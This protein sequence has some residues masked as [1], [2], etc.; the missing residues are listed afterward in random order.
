[1]KKTPK[2]IEYEN[3]TRVELSEDDTPELSEEWFKTAKHGLD[4]LAELIGEAAVA[5]LRMRGRPRKKDCKQTLTIRIPPDLIA[6][7]KNSG[8]GY[9]NKIENL[10]REAIAMGKF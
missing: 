7:I 3:K 6:A 9:G 4:G 1:M 5:P 2:Y 10:L 8:R